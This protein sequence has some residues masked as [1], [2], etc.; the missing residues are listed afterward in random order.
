MSS[1]MSADKTPSFERLL[2]SFWAV[3]AMLLVLRLFTLVASPADL[4]PDESQYWFWSRDPAFGYFSK[5]PMIAWA[6]GAT[7]AFFGNSEWAVRL[8]A[9]LLHTGAA[10]F[11]YLTVKQLFTQRIAFWTG[12]AW[13]T[14]PGVTLSSFLITTDA[15]LLFFWSSA[16]FFLFR[17]AQAPAPKLLHFIAL[18]A[19]IGF[20]LLSK[21]A[22]IYFPIAMALAMVTAPTVRR[23]LLRP[24]LLL[25]ASIAVGLLI[26]NILWNAANDFQT[27]AHTAANANWGASLFKPGNLLAFI[28][29]QFSI[30][31]PVFLSVFL[32]ASYRQWRGLSEATFDK[33][34][35]NILI[36]FALTPLI[37]VCV[38]A[39]ISRAH[40]NWA[41]AA[42]PAIIMLA[43]AWLHKHRTAWIVKA[44]VGVH[45]ALALAFALALSHFS[46]VDRLGLASAIKEIR[47]WEEQS[48]AVAAMADGYD[49]VMID[50][51]ALMGAMLYYERGTPL[52]IVA[53]DPNASISH[54]YEAFKAFDPDKHKRVL[55]V[56]TRDDDNHVNYRF[57]RIT[58]LGP[59]TVMLGKDQTRTYHLFD[60]SEFFGKRQR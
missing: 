4:G 30:A 42:Y 12:V 32:W 57:R 60:V 17:I 58:P 22:M 28:V 20:G 8:A 33:T 36:P 10:A 1:S 38:Q 31:G 13:L 34:F 47:G 15:L 19:A 41:V 53:I 48:H 26:P 43:V 45:T 51:R 3:A 39:F 2:T 35:I 11:L 49:A 18:G 29:E 5:P 27:V 56:T 24:E 16:L 25:T 9:P 6:I 40:A 54:H 23:T 59:T 46:T 50:D 55:F 44:T 21:Y 37:I 14:I 7:T 52:E